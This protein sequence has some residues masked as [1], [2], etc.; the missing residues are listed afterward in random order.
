MNNEFKK[1]LLA[2][3]IFRLL[4]VSVVMGVGLLALPQQLL[5]FQFIQPF[6]L[7][8]YVLSVGYILLWKYTDVPNLIYYIQFLFDLILISTL[9]FVSGGINSLFTPFYVLII[10][11][12]S[13]LKDR[14][15]VIIAVT[16]S[17]TSY[18]GIVHLGYLGWVPGATSIGP[19]PLLIYRISLNT[20]GF[21]AVALLGIYLSERI[22]SAR[23]E[24]GAAKVAHQNIVNSLRDGLLTLDLEGA[25]TSWNRAA[26]EISGYSEED[27]LSTEISDLFSESVSNRIL[28]SDFELSSR[29]L[30]MECWT[31]NKTGSALFLVLSCSPLLSHQR[32]QTGYILAF[33]DLT[34]IK[35]RE[36]ELQF[37]EKMAAIGQMAAGLAHEIR[38]PLGSLSGS[39]QVLQSELQL[40]DKKARL[41]EI[42]LRECDRLN[43]IVGDFLSYAGSRPGRIQPTDLLSLVHDTVEL[44]KNNPDF[45]ECHAIELSSSANPLVCQADS[46]QFKQVV[47]N[48]LQNGIRSMPDGGKLSIELYTNDSRVLMKFTDQGVG[49]SSAE[50]TKLFQPFHSG[51]GKGAGLGMSIVYQIVQQHRGSIDIE[52][53]PGSGTTVSISL[54]VEP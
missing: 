8:V 10:V 48:I 6:T 53:Y 47:W 12:A 29:A 16:L 20:L 7:A 28:K 21:L 35:N 4:L 50:K 3:I 17:I 19:Y 37:T 32:E 45:Q 13:L 26:E 44:F 54:P 36:E 52:S 9:I 49:L 11:Y 39:I 30:H 42:V 34:E 38:N 24:L 1:S 5:F 25:I 22:R 46:D 15:A 33:Q 31:Q 27:L 23:Q 40:S 14:D 41:I 51:F 43:K 18:S 2:L